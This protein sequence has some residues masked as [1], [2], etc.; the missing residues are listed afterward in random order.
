MITFAIS[1]GGSKEPHFTV[2]KPFTAMNLG[3]LP[4]GISNMMIDNLPCD[5]Y[6]FRI[7]DCE[8]LRRNSVLQPNQTK[9][10]TLA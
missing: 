5:G 1:A 9:E 4:L 10:I 3:Q 6:G 2:R 7:L 8:E